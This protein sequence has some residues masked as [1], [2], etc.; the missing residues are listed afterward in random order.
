MD[1]VPPPGLIAGETQASLSNTEGT[2]ER[3]PAID[4]LR[5]IAMT[6]VIAQHCKL[7]PC[8]WIGVWLFYVV[9]GF[10]IC[11]TLLAEQPAPPGRRYG[12]F[13]ARRFFR[14]VPVYLLYILL[15][16]VLMAVSGQYGSLSDVPFLL[17]FTYNWQM[18]FQI[19]EL[20]APFAAFGHLWTLSVEEQFY[21]IFPLLMLFLP[22]RLFFRG[23]AILVLAGP[24]IRLLFS[25]L[26][27]AV[28]AAHDPNWAAYAVY[29][30]SFTQ[31][32][33]FL[34]GALLAMAEPRLRQSSRAW[35]VPA[36]ALAAI[37][38]YV[39]VYVQ[40]NRSHGA[41]GMEAFRN[42]LSGTLYGQYREVFVYS[43]VDL[44]AASAILHVLRRGR[45][46]KLLAAPPLA[47]IGRISY[48]GYLFHALVLMLI[49]WLIEPRLEQL[50]IL[51]RLAY[52]AGAWS[53]TVAI[54]YVSFRWFESRI[55]AWSKSDGWRQRAAAGDAA[56]YSDTRLSV[57]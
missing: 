3:L 36:A 51:E 31:F 54:A 38:V 57:E 25:N 26:L 50:P 4:G 17:T 11:R 15:N 10:V 9:S 7:L 40:V 24:L 47:Q 27:A 52:F 34:L 1:I 13:V 21:L 44:V 23:A 28:P 37:V 56:G 12:R 29:A 5:A 8:G 35:L 43:V 14:I 19:W 30:A 22:R 2:R 32:D 16:L 45:G 18:I 33:A 20:H 42:V 55:T 46:T 39:L 53:A 49:T 6:M 41:V 48:G